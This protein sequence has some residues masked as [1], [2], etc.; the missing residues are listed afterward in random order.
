MPSLEK[1]K[2]A[3][4]ACKRYFNFDKIKHHFDESEHDKLRQNLREEAE[5]ALDDALFH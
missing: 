2:E 4:E 5:K 1:L 3:A